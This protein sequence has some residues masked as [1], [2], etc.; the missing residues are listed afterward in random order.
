MNIYS[1][2]GPKGSLS[3]KN[4]IIQTYSFQE[5]PGQWNVKFNATNNII[6]FPYWIIKVGDLSTYSNSCLSAV[7]KCYSWAIVSDPF[8]ATISILARDID[9]FKNKYKNSV[10]AIANVKGYNLSYNQPIEIFQSSSE[11]LSTTSI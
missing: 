7:T 1:K 9:E 2:G 10:L 4:G 11:C 3:Q 5:T 8:R 6:Y